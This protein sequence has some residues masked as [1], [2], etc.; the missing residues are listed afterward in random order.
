MALADSRLALLFVN[1]H[2]RASRQCCT[3]LLRG[4]CCPFVAPSQHSK[5]TLNTVFTAQTGLKD[6]AI[7]IYLHQGGMPW[8]LASQ[9]TEHQHTQL[10]HTTQH[11]RNPAAHSTP[12]R[13]HSRSSA[14]HTCATHTCTH[15]ASSVT[16]IEW[17][18]S[19]T[20]FVAPQ[21]GHSGLVYR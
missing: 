14:P 10:C 11:V 2:P 17:D 8:T 4:I 1:M 9:N 16:R 20:R 19:H 18:P 5:V 13:Q 3:W 12:L 7:S 21:L 6:V 15:I